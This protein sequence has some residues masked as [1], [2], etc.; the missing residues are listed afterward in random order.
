MILKRFVSR[1]FKSGFVQDL[2]SL[3]NW[4]SLV[5]IQKPGIVKECYL[6]F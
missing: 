6:I 5:K 4:L 1:T 2:E 3:E